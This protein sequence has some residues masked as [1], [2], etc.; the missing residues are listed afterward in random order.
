MGKPFGHSS[1]KNRKE[2]DYY[3][4]PYSMTQQFI[5]NFLKKN[6]WDKGYFSFLDPATGE[7]RAVEKVFNNNGYSCD[8]TDIIFGDD[9]LKTNPVKKLSNR[10]EI[11]YDWIVTN[12][13][14]SLADEFVEQARK[15]SKHGFA[16]L[17]RTN[18]LSG[19][20]RFEDGRFRDLKHVFIFTRMTDLKSELREDGKYKTAMIVYA[21]FV[22]EHNYNGKPMIDWIDKQKFVLKKGE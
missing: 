15:N 5:D 14:Y 2:N 4:T 10:T 9:F 22:W 6:D 12:P 19:Q 1:E 17:L 3:P 16:M 8:G 20:K 7:A 21:W 11:K 18:F 13:P